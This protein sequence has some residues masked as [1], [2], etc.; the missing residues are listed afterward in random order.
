MGFT[1]VISDVHGHLDCFEAI[2]EKIN[3]QPDDRLYI[4]GDVIDRG[5]RGIEILKRIMAMPNA[6]MLLGNHEFMMLNALG[7]PYDGIR[8]STIDSMELW[9]HNGGLLT[10]AAFQSQPKKIRSDIVDF[11]KSL[12]LNIDVDVDSEKYRLVHAADR[13]LYGRYKKMYTSEAEYAVW[14]REALDFMR[15]TVTNYV[16]GHTMTGMLIER[17]P[18]RIIFKGNLIGIDCGCAVIP[19]SLNHQ[20]LGA[21]GGRLTCIRLEDKKCFYSDEEVKPAVIRSRKR[22]IITMEA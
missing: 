1:Y 14:S 12:P 8:R 10:F 4:F 5:F 19:N 20:I 18:M 15:R 7:E 13:E 6:E 21:Q 17:S 9:Y 3:L 22:G 16:F 2:L 11:L